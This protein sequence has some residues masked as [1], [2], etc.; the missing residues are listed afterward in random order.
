MRCQFTPAP[1]QGQGAR[2]AKNDKVSP[3][4]VWGFTLIE[5]MIAISILSIGI[6]AVL[7]IIFW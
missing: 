3:R 5:T 1:Q 6:V 4:L 2:G 7:Y